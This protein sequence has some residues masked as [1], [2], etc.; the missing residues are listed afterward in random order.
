[1]NFFAFCI[2]RSYI[3]LSTFIHNFYFIFPSQFLFLINNKH[4]FISPTAEISYNIPIHLRYSVKIIIKYYHFREP[5]QTLMVLVFNFF[6]SC[7]RFYLMVVCSTT[8][9]NIKSITS[10][11][12]LTRCNLRSTLISFF[13]CAYFASQEAKKADVCTFSAWLKDILFQLVWSRKIVFYQVYFLVYGLL[14]LINLL[15]WKFSLV[16]SK[17]MTPIL[18]YEKQWFKRIKFHTIHALKYTKYTNKIQ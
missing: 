5:Q 9:H 17:K 3:H 10:V 12:L 14:L 1:M 13:L 6:F 7:L 18:F 2:A 11:F 4:L 8:N 16:Q 15:S